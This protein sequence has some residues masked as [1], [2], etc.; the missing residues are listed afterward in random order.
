MLYT[1]VTNC[2]VLGGV[3]IIRSKLAIVQLS[4]FQKRPCSIIVKS[5]GFKKI[6]KMIIF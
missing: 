2:G 3:V 6:L 4:V 1:Y 5:V